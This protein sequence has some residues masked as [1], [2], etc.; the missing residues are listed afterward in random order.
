MPLSEIQRKERGMIATIYELAL[1]H[2]LGDICISMAT[3]EYV[4]C[5]EEP[6]KLTMDNPEQM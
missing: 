3:G 6:E 5:C 4:V 1:C 2:F